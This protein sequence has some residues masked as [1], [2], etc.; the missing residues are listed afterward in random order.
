MSRRAVRLELEG[1]I[2]QAMSLCPPS[3]DSL[4]N[5]HFSVPR[6]RRKRDP[7]P[8]SPLGLGEGERSERQGGRGERQCGRRR[9]EG[10]TREGRGRRG[11]G[12]GEGG[13]VFYLP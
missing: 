7:L 6:L 9:E 4:M 11:R 13:R 1:E 5:C 3:S 12:V 8:P 10:G 2:C